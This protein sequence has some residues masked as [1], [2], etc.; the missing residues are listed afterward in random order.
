MESTGRKSGRLEMM[1]GFPLVV[2]PSLEAV[3]VLGAQTTSTP[4]ALPWQGEGICGG[5]HH[6]EVVGG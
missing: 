2:V 4:L 5:P 1:R 3:S 6:Q